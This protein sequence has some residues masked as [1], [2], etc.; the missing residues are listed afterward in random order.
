MRNSVQ[1]RLEQIRHIKLVIKAKQAQIEEL[2]QT[3]DSVKSSLS[4]AGGSGGGGASNATYTNAIN[5]IIDVQFAIAAEQYALAKAIEDISLRIKNMREDYC[6]L[7]LILEL[8]YIN[9]M[10]WSQI[11]ALMNYERRNIYY[12]HAEALEQFKNFL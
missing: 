1:Q 11:R 3:A 12:L 7:A 4:G 9:C 8:R 2:R 6:Q 5:K 10:S